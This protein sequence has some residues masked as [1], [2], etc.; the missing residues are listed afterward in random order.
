MRVLLLHLALIGLFFACSESSPK[1]SN[2]SD[3]KNDSISKLDTL[4]W[5]GV[6][7]GTV[8]NATDIGLE[9]KLSLNPSNTYDLVITHL[10]S[11]PKD[12]VKREFSGEIHWIDDSTTIELKEIDSLSNK[13]KIR[14]GQVDY[15]NPDATPN[16]GKLAEFYVLKK[17]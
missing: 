11:N 2:L 17:K 4:D 13:F 8:P 14:P 10:R 6:Y 7:T 9:M 12:N 1:Q 15:L 16:T 5:V 3:L